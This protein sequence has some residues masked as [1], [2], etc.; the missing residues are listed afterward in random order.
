MAHHRKRIKEGDKYIIKIAERPPLQIKLKKGLSFLKKEFTKIP[1]IGD[2]LK[3]FHW[4]WESKPKKRLTIENLSVT[5]KQMLKAEFKASNSRLKSLAG[6]D[7]D[8]LKKY[9]YL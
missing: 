9:G 7:E 4:E 3:K 1:M 2:H 6:L 8:K 5:E